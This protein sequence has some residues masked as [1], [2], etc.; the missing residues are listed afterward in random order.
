MI[1][2]RYIIRN[3][4]GKGRSQVYLCSDVEFP[5][6]DLAVKILPPDAEELETRI[7]RS[8]FFTLRKL[9]H[10]NI[11][12][13]NEFSSVVKFDEEEN[14]QAGSMFFVMEYFRG[15]ILSGCKKL[16]DENFLRKIIEQLCS[17]LYYLHQSN[18]IY[19]DL[20]PENILINE[21]DGK[22]LIKMIDLGFAQNIYHSTEEVVRGTAEYI[23]PEILRREAHDHRADLYSL[24]IMLYKFI[25]G[26]FP[27]EAGN[28]LEI[29]K[30]HLEKEFEFPETKYSSRLINTL[31]K[32]LAKNPDDRYQNALQLLGEL[33]IPI[34]EN[35]SKD[36]MPAKIF[37]DRTDVLT[38]L[39]TYFED[40][41][42][43]E[44]FTIKG[45]EGSGK[46]SLV[47]EIYYRHENVILIK[48]NK[49]KAGFDFIKLILKQIVFNQFVF[50]KLSDEVKEKIYAIFNSPSQDLISE[51]KIIF[52][53]VS[54]QNN[55]VLIL[56]AFNFYDEFAVEVF[57]NII[58]ILQVNKIKV[59][60]TENS[61]FSYLSSFIFNLREINLI[62]FTE[63]HLDEFITKSFYKNFP[64]EDLKKLILKY[65]DLLPGSIEGF[66]RDI[67]LLKIATFDPNGVNINTGDETLSI[68]KGSQ[69]EI[70]R[71]RFS[72]LNEEEIKISKL[73]SA[74][75]TTLDLPSIARLTDFAAEKIS[76]I[77]SS[78]QNKN[79]IQQYNRSA[80]IVF[81]SDGIK[82]YAYLQIDNAPDYHLDIANKLK[83][84]F[85]SFNKV[86]IARHFELASQ[87]YKSYELYKEEIEESE[88]LSTY[89]YQK[90]ILLHLLQLNL[91]DKD[92]ID[93]RFRLIN[94]Y[95]KLGENKQALMLI[96]ELLSE[97]E[98]EDFKL[99]ILIVKGSCL[100]GL[101]EN[102]AGKNL[103]ETLLPRIED[104]TRKQTILA[105]IASA[106]LELNN[107]DSVITLCKS[108]INNPHATKMDIAKC[109]NI[110]G[111]IGLF[112]NDILNESLLYIQK[113][114]DIYKSLN[115]NNRVAQ[116]EK[117]IGIIYDLQGYHD[118][119]EESWN[120]SLQ[121]NKNIG[122]IEEEAKLLLNFGIINYEKQN[123]PKAIENYKNAM[124]IFQ[125]LGNKLGVGQSLSNLGELYLYICEY[126][127]SY[128]SIER[129]ILIYSQLDYI[130]TKL[131][132]Q[133][134]L[135]KLFLVIG[136]YEWFSELF[137][138]L[139]LLEKEGSI[140]DKNKTQFE[141]LLQLE[142]ASESFANTDIQKLYSLQS[143]FLKQ[144]DKLHYF[145]ATILIVKN[146]IAFDK[147]EDAA[148]VLVSKEIEEMVKDNV[149]FFAEREYMLGKIAM[150]NPGTN[151]KPPIDYFISAFSVMEDFSLTELT[152]KILFEMGNY[153]YHRGNYSKA[154]EYLHYAKEIINYF[155]ENITDSHLHEAYLKESER[156]RT[157]EIITKLGI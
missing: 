60:L 130:L 102:E 77:I 84:K 121:S 118:K 4:I 129:S 125:S 12:K 64:R 52:T 151:L 53:A 131:R 157:L 33:N 54:M 99:E 140:N 59:I 100:I 137:N 116:L 2:E 73:I 20:K 146:L 135:S 26:K 126:Q 32:L 139:S 22:P 65:A 134:L 62:P 107:F 23:A 6:T 94:V 79:I 30:S 40:E 149:L 43:N 76:S 106:E 92:L 14:I 124:L 11:I 101:G 82:K 57:K 38:I 117:N 88:K 78:L 8:E 122:S 13:A 123:I 103:F 36:W 95:H 104:E 34:D 7:F 136:D 70:Y 63:I 68:L 119:A 153:Y 142:K 17:V 112:R 46:T 113:A 74:F 50:E 37:S 21:I 31:R 85:S 10:P 152:W 69:E 5:E 91:E 71:L 83:E 44:V 110:W 114:K 109:Y 48:N 108:V 132:A 156:S 144:N 105:E 1:N 55:F 75:D 90:N 25:Y 42:S 147:T 120:I 16:S 24:G 141:Y 72:N 89:S 145:A 148:A 35:L 150:I 138:Q 96:E 98:D 19:Y 67:I 9:D 115:M 39:K 41:T 154:K 61:D 51:L 28:E 58:P 29:Y 81:T 127:N 47:D 56:D 111:L 93:I 49:A 15:E 86:E 66:L 45:F 97:A 87:H 3:K 133:L 155:A 27:F 128:V 80:G 143:E 18:Y